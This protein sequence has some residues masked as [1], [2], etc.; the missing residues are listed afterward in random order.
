MDRVGHDLM[1]KQQ[2]KGGMLCTEMYPTSS[3]YVEVLS[4]TAL[5]HDLIWK[6]DLYRGNQVKLRSLSWI[7]I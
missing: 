3:S 5:E 4:P 2:Y 1:T 6:Q 7:L